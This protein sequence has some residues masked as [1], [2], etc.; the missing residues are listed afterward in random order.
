MAMRYGVPYDAF[1]DMSPRSIEPWRLLYEDSEQDRVDALDYQA[2]LIGSYVL[3][4]IGST[5]DRRVRY[6]SQPESVTRRQQTEK[7]L[8]NQENEIAAAK[9]RSWAM[10]FNAQMKSNAEG[11]T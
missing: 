10:A 2:W 5:L 6:P 4:A 8:E 9:F 3:T 7:A 11:G 1:W